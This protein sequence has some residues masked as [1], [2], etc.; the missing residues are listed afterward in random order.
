MRPHDD[1]YAILQVESSCDFQALKKA[2]YRRAMDCHP[3]RFGGDCRKE[4]EFKRVVN[5]FQVLSDPVQRGRYDAGRRVESARDLSAVVS[6]EAFQRYDPD[7][8]LDTFADDILEELIVGN[9]VPEHTSLATLMLDLVRTERFCLLREGKNLF[10]AG[11]L[12]GAARIFLHY[13]A[14]SPDNILVRYFL[15]RC[16][17]L[18]RQYRRAEREFRQAIRVAESRRPPLH[19]PRIRRE[20]DQLRRK[21]RSLVGRMRSLFSSADPSASDVTPEEEMRRA[22]SRAIANLVRE[23]SIRRRGLPGPE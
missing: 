20:L 17:V 11:D 7:A 4:E 16:F 6:E 8:I 5:A 2:Y 9:T 19:V 10:Y 14:D 1:W 15:G 23:E 22:V 21:H 18:G 3:D 13:L 12:R